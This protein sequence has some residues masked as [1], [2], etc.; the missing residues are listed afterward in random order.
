M[1]APLWHDIGFSL[2]V[3]ICNLENIMFQGHKVVF[4]RMVN[5]IET[6][7]GETHKYGKD[8]LVLDT[9]V[10]NSEYILLDTFGCKIFSIGYKDI[11]NDNNIVFSLEQQ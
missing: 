10:F 8:Y 11:T 3:P 4:L 7:K 9:S 6:V 5:R 2:L 1:A